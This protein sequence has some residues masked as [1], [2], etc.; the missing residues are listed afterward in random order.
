VPFSPQASRNLAG[1]VQGGG[2]VEHGHAALSLARLHQPLGQ[3]Q[4]GQQAFRVA[5]V[6]VL[7]QIV[8][9]PA[10]KVHPAGRLQVGHG[11]Q[12]RGR[13]NQQ[14]LV[15]L[16]LGLAG[17]FP[18]EGQASLAQGLRPGWRLDRALDHTAQDVKRSAAVGQLVSGGR[19]VL[20]LIFL[21]LDGFAQQLPGQQVLRIDP[22]GLIQQVTRFVVQASFEQDL[23]VQPADGQVAWVVRQP[24]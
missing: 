14:G 9:S 13:F 2:L 22:A 19:L 5:F 7:G 11:D 4:Q 8:H 3:H 24:G 12:G 10:R 21:A 17:V 23:G 1:H 18:I 20:F 16:L 6:V 15:D